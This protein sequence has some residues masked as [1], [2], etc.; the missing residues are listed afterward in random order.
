MKVSVQSEQLSKD[1]LR[2]LLQAIR[3]CEQKHFKDKKISIIAKV[4]E[5]GIDET[6]KILTSIK[7]PFSYGPFGFRVGDGECVEISQ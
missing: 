6:M 5:L 4:P 3:D 7:P 1:D 2:L